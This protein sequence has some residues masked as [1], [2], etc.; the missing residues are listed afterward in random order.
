MHPAIPCLTPRPPGDPLRYL[1][2]H[3]MVDVLVTT[4][5]GVEEDLIKCMGNTYLGDWAL[6]GQ[7][8]QQEEGKE[9]GGEEGR[10]AGGGNN[11]AWRVG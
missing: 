5:G 9:G 11:R 8:E 1:V 6:K 2:Q 10:G 3:R 4:A 7:T